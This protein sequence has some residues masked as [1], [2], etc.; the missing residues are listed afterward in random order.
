M[1]LLASAVSV[2]EIAE[3]DLLALLF[4]V[5]SASQSS[6]SQIARPLLVAALQ[7]S[8]QV[9]VTSNLRQ[10]HSLVAFAKLA[11]LFRLVAFSHVAFVVPSSWG[12]SGS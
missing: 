2:E 7:W 4:S 3:V 10:C 11:P 5:P 9:L 1:S 8:E 12:L 6:E